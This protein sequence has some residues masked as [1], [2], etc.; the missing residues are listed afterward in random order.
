MGA[1]VTDRVGSGRCHLYVRRLFKVWVGIEE[2]RTPQTLAL[3]P[4]NVTDETERELLHGALLLY[5]CP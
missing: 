1:V 2:E 5:R 4:T 3:G